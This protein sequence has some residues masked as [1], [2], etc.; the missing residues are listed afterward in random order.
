MGYQYG[1]LLNE[2]I[3]ETFSTLVGWLLSEISAESTQPITEPALGAALDAILLNMAPFI[4]IEYFEEAA[5]ISAGALEKGVIISPDKVLQAVTFAD[6]AEFAIP[7]E[8]AIPPGFM[9]D[10]SFSQGMS[11][12]QMD[13]IQKIAEAMPIQ[14]SFFA[15]WDERSEDG[16]LYGTRNLDW[17]EDTGIAK[18]KLLTIYN[19]DNGN[20]YVTMGWTGYIGA[21]AGMSENGLAVG[22][23]G[24][25]NY[26]QKIQGC[27]WGIMLREV[28]SKADDLN[29]GI[30]TF[31]KTQHTVGIN[32]MLADGDADRYGTKHY[33]PSARAIETNGFN[34]AVF[35]DNDPA[36]DLA[37]YTDEDGVGHCYALKLENAIFRADVALD[38]TIR[39]T[40]SADNG[41]YGDPRD[42]G[43]YK[44]RYLAQYNILKDHYEDRITQGNDPTLIGNEQAIDLLR[45]VAMD[46]N[47]LSVVYG[48]TTLDFWVAYETGGNDGSGEEWHFAPYHE[49]MR[50]NLKHLLEK[51]IEE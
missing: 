49:Y 30:E 6:I 33:S 16:K 20:A 3:N 32:F 51:D 9:P 27:P 43:S 31:Q 11:A 25:Q 34:T 1:Y 42:G 50:L 44:N 38:P 47:V 14:C 2:K 22:E 35:K 17:A 37:I 39:S 15:A 13:I 46:C 24:A 36:E 8:S 26:S 28:L 41:P 19:P 21:M 45:S 18:N 7:D 23:I 40:Q 29:A 48:A 4:P 12:E 10:M 5:G